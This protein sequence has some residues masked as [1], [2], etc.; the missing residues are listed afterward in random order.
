LIGAAI[1]IALVPLFGWQA[2]MESKATCVSNERRL[3]TSLLLYAQDYDWRLPRHSYKRDNGF[4]VTWVDTVMP[5]M[6]GRQVALC[7]ATASS[8]KGSATGPRDNPYSYALNVRFYDRFQ[9][10]PYPYENLELPAQTAMVVET[11]ARGP[12]SPS[13]SGYWD[14]TV[15]TDCYPVPHGGRANVAA[16]DGHVITVKIARHAPG[17][18]D[19]LYGRFGGSMFNWNG[20]HP[21]GDTTGRARE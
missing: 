18:H 6:P 10:G 12:K 16:A 15:D 21:N 14:T 5:D 9:P 3:A 4:V 13:V 7:P 11:A 17:D 8:Q 1:A 20:G 2:T 19:V